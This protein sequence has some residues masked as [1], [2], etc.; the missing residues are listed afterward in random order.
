[1][2]PFRQI[3]LHRDLKGESGG[4]LKL[5]LQHSAERTCENEMKEK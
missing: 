2:I 5:A 3:T 4:L 1:M